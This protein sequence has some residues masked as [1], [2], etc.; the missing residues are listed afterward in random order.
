MVGPMQRKDI[1]AWR[2]PGVKQF[3][4]NREFHWA[5][6]RRFGALGGPCRSCALLILNGLGIMAVSMPPWS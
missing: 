3:T 2:S 6:E 5:R 1:G 4:L